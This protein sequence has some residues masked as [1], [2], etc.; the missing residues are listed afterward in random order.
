MPLRLFVVCSCLGALAGG[1]F[2]LVRGLDYLPTLPV[3]IV[4]GGFLI[5][6]PSAVLGALLAG[7]WWVSRATYQRLTR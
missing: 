1:I 3:A 6:V 2:G 7:S 4:E 5:G